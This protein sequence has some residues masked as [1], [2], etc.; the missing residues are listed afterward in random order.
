MFIAPVRHEAALCGL[1]GD[2]IGHHGDLGCIYRV[3]ADVATATQSPI[4]GVS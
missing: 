4:K 1:E 3:A 2:D